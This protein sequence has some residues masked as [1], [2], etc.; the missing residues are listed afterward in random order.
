MIKALI[1][2]L[3][4]NPDLTNALATAASVVVALAALFLSGISLVVA[5]ASLRLQ[6]RHNV[7]SVKP[8]PLVTV[9]DHEN[10]LRIKLRNHGSG[11]LIVTGISVTDGKRQK[12]SLI[13]WMPDLPD[14]L[15]WTNFAGPI[16]EQRGLLP[17]R[18][19]VLLELDGDRHDPTFAKARDSV[20]SVLKDLTVNV[21]YTDIY[22]SK[23]DSYSHDLS[24]FG[25]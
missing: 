21:E 5:L 10:S 11:P 18:E 13:D 25:R 14:E 19:L 9:A 2:T 7:L 17:D 22:G 12:R 23:F 1:E 15:L 3:A 6:R 24:W 16:K 8:I 4:R 20:R